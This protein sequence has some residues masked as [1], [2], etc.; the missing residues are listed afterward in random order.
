[1]RVHGERRWEGPGDFAFLGA[2]PNIGKIATK[3][4][5]NKSYMNNPL[6]GSNMNDKYIKHLGDLENYINSHDMKQIPG[7]K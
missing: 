3:Q 4:N 7:A 5:I 1:L 2:Q 6:G